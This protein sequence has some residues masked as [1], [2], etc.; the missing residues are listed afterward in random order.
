MTKE[1]K[2]VTVR[3][4]VEQDF[5]VE[6][7]DNKRGGIHY[8]GDI[9]ASGGYNIHDFLT[10]DYLF[11]NPVSELRTPQGKHLYSATLFDMQDTLKP[12]FFE[13]EEDEWSDTDND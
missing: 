12:C 13:G 10:H 5:E 7:R 8:M 4:V 6:V 9:I 1:K 3:F 2:I 11:E